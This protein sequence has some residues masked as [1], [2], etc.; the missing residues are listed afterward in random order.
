MNFWG[1]KKILGPED[2]ASKWSFSCEAGRVHT[3][4][5]TLCGLKLL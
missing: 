4:P 5:V 2:A 1:T 3:I